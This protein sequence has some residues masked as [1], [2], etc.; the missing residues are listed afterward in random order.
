MFC[1][2]ALLPFQVTGCH[3]YKLAHNFIMQV[4]SRSLL[5]VLSVIMMMMMTMPTLK[6]LCI[7]T[8]HSGQ[9]P[10]YLIISLSELS[11]AVVLWLYSVETAVKWY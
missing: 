3:T 1:Q 11:P 9:C 5:L 7:N 4:L 10:T 8:L 6:M 2:L